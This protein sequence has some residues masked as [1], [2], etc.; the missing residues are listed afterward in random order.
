MAVRIPMFAD[1]VCIISTFVGYIAMLMPV[2]MLGLGLGLFPAIGWNPLQPYAGRSKTR[3]AVAQ[4]QGSRRRLS[5]RGGKQH[6]AI[7]ATVKVES[8][9]RVPSCDP[10]SG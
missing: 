2:A 10:I 1:L 4:L 3:L 8:Q 9:G 7:T 5:L 6:A